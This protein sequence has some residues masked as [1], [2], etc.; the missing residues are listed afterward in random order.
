MKIRRVPGDPKP[1]R[2]NE[3][4]EGLP[5][6]TR[7]QTPVSI[8]NQLFGYACKIFEIAASRGLVVTMEN[9]SSSYFWLTLWVLRLIK[10]IRTYK[11]DF[12]VC[13]YGSGRDKWTRLLSNVSAIECMSVRCDRSHSRSP[14]GFALDDEGRQVWATSLESQYPRKLCVVFVSLVLHFAEQHGLQLKAHSL[15]DEHQNPLALAQKSQMG[16]TR[17][18]KS[19]KIA[20]LVPDFCS[21]ATF[22]VKKPSEV[23]CVLMSKISKPLTL[24][25][26]KG[27]PQQA[28]ALSRFLR[29]ALQPDRSNG[30][31]IQL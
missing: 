3:F 24:H 10:A 22:F 19:S 23:R 12:Q 28:P 29:I 25:T 4:P 8:A 1:L 15:S 14:W 17:Q 9:P 31:A 26:D 13:M 7:D 30:G 21:V 27:M 5:N 16:A 2:S 11:A 20:P 6:S 18:P